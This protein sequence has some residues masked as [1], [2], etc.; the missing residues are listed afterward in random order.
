MPTSFFAKTLRRAV[1]RVVW[2]CPPHAVGLLWGHRF[3]AL[4]LKIFFVFVVLCV[5]FLVIFIHV[6]VW[7]FF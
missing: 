4:G 3:Q 1:L 7:L 5:G 6:F 2:V